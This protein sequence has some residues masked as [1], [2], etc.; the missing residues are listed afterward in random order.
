[1]ETEEI[2]RIE[3]AIRHIQT[4]VDVDPWAVEI[5]VEAMRKQIPKKPVDNVDHENSDL[6]RLDCPTCGRYVGYRA[7]GVQHTWRASVSIRCE[8]CGQAIDWRGESDGRSDQ[9]TSGD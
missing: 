7:K 8:L 3:C 5:A 1:M 2:D 4:A 9:Q 6:Y